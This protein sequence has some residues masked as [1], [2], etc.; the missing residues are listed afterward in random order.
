VRI[1]QVGVYEA[2][3]KKIR[4]FVANHTHN[5]SVSSYMRNLI[6]TEIARIEQAEEEYYKQQKVNG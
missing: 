4:E 6:L 5:Q 2:Q 1:I 3:W